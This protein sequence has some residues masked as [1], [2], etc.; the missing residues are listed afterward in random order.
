[1]RLNRYLALKG[2]ATRRKA[3]ELIEAGL[4]M[5]D[6]RVAEVGEK[7]QHGQEVVTLEKG[8]KK[9][10][11]NLVYFA[12][13]KPRGIITHSPQGQERA[14]GDVISMKGIFPVGRLDKESEGLIILTNDGRITERLLHP[15][16]AHE[17]EYIV[18]IQ[19]T[20]P[21]DIQTVLEN[22]VQENGE[23][24]KAKKVTLLSKHQAEI[25]LT[26]GK[27]HQIRRMLGASNL[28]VT[29]LKRLRIMGVHLGSLQPGAKRAI[30]GKAKDSFLSDLGLR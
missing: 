16:F 11:E 30:A 23:L 22:G 1:M 26:E 25:I 7:L 13:Y 24:L 17:K 3:D 15:R 21:R 29:E 27:K 9:T 20:W 6:G 2:I 12:Y 10:T 19:E 4:V 14:I 8:V 28:S 18:T 5:I